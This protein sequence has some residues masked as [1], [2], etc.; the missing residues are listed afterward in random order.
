[1]YALQLSG[2]YMSLLQQQARQYA[3]QY[4]LWTTLAATWGTSYVCQ[5]D[6]PTASRSQWQQERTRFHS[7]L[8]SVDWGDGG[9]SDFTLQMQ[10]I[11][12]S[13]AGNSFLPRIVKERLK[14]RLYDIRTATIL[15]ADGSPMQ[16]P[17]MGAR[18]SFK[19]AKISLGNKWHS[20]DFQVH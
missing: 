15:M 11:A 20:H 12:D 2:P 5:V 13:G 9:K 19:F 7:A 16:G 17:S 8:V 3:G 6:G 4:E 1:M 10:V 18:A 14:P